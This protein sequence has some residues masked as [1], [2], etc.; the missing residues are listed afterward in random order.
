MEWKGVLGSILA[1]ESVVN[2]REDG[3]RAMAALGADAS[4]FFVTVARQS[5]PAP[6]CAN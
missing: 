3:S 4:F 5:N 6:P 1:A 2:Y